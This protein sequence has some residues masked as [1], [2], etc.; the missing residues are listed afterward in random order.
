MDL[1]GFLAATFCRG[2]PLVFAPTTLLG[3]VDAC[4]GGKNGV[5]CSFGKNL[6]GS[7]YPPAL[8]FLDLEMLTTL[9]DRAWL[10]GL[11]E[12]IKY[13]LIAAPD[14]FALL[15]TQT[16]ATLKKKEILQK[17]I[18]RSLTIKHAIVMR[19]PEERL[20]ERRILNFGHTIAH[21]LE[22]ESAYTL[23][24]GAALYLGMRVESLI[25]QEM[26]MLSQKARSDI[27][28]LLS[29]FAIDI[30]H[31]PDQAKVKR[32]FS[33]DKKAIHERPRFVLLQQIGKAAPCQGAYCTHV[34][35]EIIENALKTCL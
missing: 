29:R 21:A 15:Q 22:V 32:A 13:A 26:G 27:D 11:S 1:V 25:S 8:I 3:M 4:M 31:S 12:V 9:E 19:D 24:H 28:A 30:S 7:F 33:R 23:S 10:E 18:E 5:N 35:E 34:P 14:L 2:V 6:I 17:M 16:L 20:G